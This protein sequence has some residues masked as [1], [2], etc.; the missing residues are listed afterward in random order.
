MSFFSQLKDLGYALRIVVCDDNEA[1]KLAVRYVY[2]R[3]LIQTCQK[4]FL[5]NLRQDLNIRSSHQYEFFFYR[6][7]EVLKFQVDPAEFNL[8]LSQIDKEFEGR[9]DEKVSHWLGEMLRLKEELLAYQQVPNSP[10]TTN[11]IEAYN[12][13]LEGRLKTIKGFQSFHSA[14]LWLNGYVLRRRLKAFTDCEE[15]FK[16]L[17]GK[18]PLKNSLQTDL[19]LPQIFN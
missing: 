7:E 8:E 12:S 15:P 3:A 18:P 17:N 2:P 6:L 10:W 14:D 19:K 13:H 1:I 16:H 5:E 4:H 11:L 9:K